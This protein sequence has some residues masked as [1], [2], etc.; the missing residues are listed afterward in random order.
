MSL[1]SSNKVETNRYELV[2]EIDGETFMKAVDAVYKRQV[3]NINIPGFRKGKAPRRLIEKEYGEGV[4]YE[5]A[6][7]NLYPA[8]IVEAA[9]EAGLN[10][11]RDKVDLDVEEAGKDGLT[12]KAVITVEP[13]VEI[14]DYKG[15]EYT[16]KSLEVTDEDIDEEIKKVQKRNSRLVSVEDREAQNEDIAVIDFKGILDGEAFE[17]GSA[18]NYSLTLGSGAFIP[19]FED[20]V[21]GHKAGEEF[22]IDVTFPE[23]Y[24]A[25][26]LKGKAVQFEI[27]LHEVKTHELPEVDDEFVKDIS[28]FETVNE[29]KADLKSKLEESRKTEADNSKEQQIAE[30]LTE[31]L[32][33][34]I[35]EAMYDNQ[36]DHIIDEFAMN[37]RSQGIDLNTYMEY[38][39]L[40]E[41]KLRET[42]YDRAETQVKLRL[43]LKKIAELEGLKASDE[44]VEA[45]YNEL[46]ETYKVDVSRVKA[47]F[48]KKDI[49]GDIETERAMNLVKENAVEK[50][51]DAE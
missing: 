16:P 1:K 17:G 26:E 7:K 12:F 23:D 30:K 10:I 22:T 33:A 44:D 36:L 50:A 39:G 34:E 40:T 42:Y 48:D 4:F 46:S 8:A 41:D 43:A 9:D 49:A 51:A 32:E 24:Q 45:K 11:V 6:I 3:K 38:T 29:Y 47:A 19:G 31:L 14:K 13:E 21:V 25:D 20:Q 28:E 35:P 15:I 27:K 5:D 18:E 2:V 37:L